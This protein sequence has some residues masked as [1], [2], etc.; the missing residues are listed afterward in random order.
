M[1]QYQITISAVV[2][3]ECSFLVSMNIYAIRGRHAETVLSIIS[4]SIDSVN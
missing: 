4:H 3:T 2:V 1:D